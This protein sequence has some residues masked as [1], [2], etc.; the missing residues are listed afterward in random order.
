MHVDDVLA[1]QEFSVDG[2]VKKD[3]IR[4]ENFNVV[5]I[6]LETDVEIPP[7]PEPYA[8]FFQVL[9]GEGVFTNSAGSFRLGKG[10]GLFIEANGIR[11]IKCLDRLVVLGV[12]DGH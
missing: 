7:H 8:V 1:L 3:L 5:L 9:E 12:Q 6:C 4:S 10:S 2:P 11:G